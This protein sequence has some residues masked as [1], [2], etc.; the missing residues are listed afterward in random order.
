[1]RY[2]A[3]FTGSSQGT[4]V[5]RA[6]DGTLLADVE[7][8]TLLLGKTPEQG[9]V[10]VSCQGVSAISLYRRAA[11]HEHV[12]TFTIQASADGSI[13]GV[14]NADGVTAVGTALNADFPHGLLVAHDD[15]NQL[16]TRG[17][18]E[19]TAF[20]LVS[21]ADILGQEGHALLAEVDEMW[22]PRA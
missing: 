21:I 11:P 3:E 5:V 18:A 19:L 14:I 8:V 20:K 22:N 12:M 4:L 1:M 16:A 9:F 10:I 7:K 13:D 2:D 15:A 6:G 17:T